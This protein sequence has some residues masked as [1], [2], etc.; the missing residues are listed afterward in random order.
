MTSR[1]QAS[2]EP[3]RHLDEQRREHLQL[4]GETRLSDAE[5][6]A[7]REAA[8]EIERKLLGATGVRLL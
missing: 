6:Q 2:P 5:R 4:A 7:H 8:A 3:R 1:A